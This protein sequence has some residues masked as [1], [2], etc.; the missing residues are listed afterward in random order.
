MNTLTPEQHH[1]EIRFHRTSP[2]S[3]RYAVPSAQFYAGLHARAQ[4]GR[5]ARKLHWRTWL[6]TPI[7]RA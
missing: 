2:Q 4:K 1:A 3:R 6:M 7:E 5:E